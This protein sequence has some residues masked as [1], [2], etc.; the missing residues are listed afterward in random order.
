MFT[1]EFK[2]K[3]ELPSIDLT[4]QRSGCQ[5]SKKWPQKT[6]GLEKNGLK[7]IGWTKSSKPGF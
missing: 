4:H 6:S 2:L 3:Q 1:L 7:Y 5:K